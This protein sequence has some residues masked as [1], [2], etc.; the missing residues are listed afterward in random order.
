MHGKAYYTIIGRYW[1]VNSTDLKPAHRRA[2]N[3]KSAANLLQ[4]DLQF[5]FPSRLSWHPMTGSSWRSSRCLGSRQ[6]DLVFG[7]LRA[8]TVC[9]R[10]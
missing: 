8:N 5:T 3:R 7:A 1:T 2:G 4:V 6:R 9:S 10:G